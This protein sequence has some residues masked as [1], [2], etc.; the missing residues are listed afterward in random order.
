MG[1]IQHKMSTHSFKKEI[2][3]LF[4]LAIKT[5]T[6][7]WKGSYKAISS[8][9]HLTKI[10]N[11]QNKNQDFTYQYHNS[12]QKRKMRALPAIETGGRPGYDEAMG[13]LEEER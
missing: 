6:N 10:K 7:Q 9:T 8:I 2:T 4:F 5:C 3:F 1:Y 12:Y 13:W 11:L